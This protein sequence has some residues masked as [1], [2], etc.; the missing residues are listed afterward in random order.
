M[1]RL[2]A[3]AQR[4]T[5]QKEEKR[6]KKKK[7][8]G[9]EEKGRGA[10]RCKQGSDSDRLTFAVC[11][12]SAAS[13]GREGQTPSQ[14]MVVGAEEAVATATGVARTHGWTQPQSVPKQVVFIRQLI[15]LQLVTMV[16]VHHGL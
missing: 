14:R 15:V 1:L 11:P 8:K 6:K 4:K 10:G 7:K 9:I 3:T 12:A 2:C 16:T 5:S 13:R